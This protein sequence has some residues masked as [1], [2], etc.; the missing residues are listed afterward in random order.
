MADQYTPPKQLP[1]PE[2]PDIPLSGFSDVLLAEECSIPA[3]SQDRDFYVESPLLATCDIPSGEIIGINSNCKRNLG[4][5]STSQGES[6]NSD[7]Y[8]NPSLVSTCDIPMDEIIGDCGDNT[9]TLGKATNKRIYESDDEVPET[10]LDDSI[11][12]LDHKNQKKKHSKL[13]GPVDD[14]SVALPSTVTGG[15]VEFWSAHSSDAES[16]VGFGNSPSWSEQV[17]SRESEC[18]PAISSEGLLQTRKNLISNRVFNDTNN[19]TSHSKGTGRVILI[20]PS[21]SHPLSKIMNSPK[22]FQ[23]ALNST[24]FGKANIRDIRPNFKRGIIVIELENHDDIDKFDLLNITQMGEWSIK[25]AQPKSDIYS[26][27]IIAPIETDEE[28]S[29]SDLRV[30]GNVP[31]I[32]A[33]RLMRTVEDGKKVPSKCIKITFE[34]KDLPSTVKIDYFSFKVRRFVPSPLQCF[35]CQRLGHTSGGCKS[36]RPRCL[37]CKGP[38]SIKDK[39]CNTQTPKCANCDG[40]HKA[41][42]YLCNYLQ[43]GYNQDREKT[44]NRTPVVPNG[45]EGRHKN[46]S[47]QMVVNSSRKEMQVQAEVHHSMN[48]QVE[49]PRFSSY[50]DRVSSRSSP[51]SE[52]HVN[53]KTCRSCRDMGNVLKKDAC[54]QT[55]PE[56][57][58]K[59]KVVD[60]FDYSKLYKCLVELF[61]SNILR[62]SIPVRETLVKAALRHSFGKTILP[63]SQEVTAAQSDDNCDMEEEEEQEEDVLSDTC[64]ATIGSGT[65]IPDTPST[66]DVQA[67]TQINNCPQRSKGKKPNKVVGRKGQSIKES[68]K[69]ALQEHQI[70]SIKKKNK[71]KRINK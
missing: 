14:S 38:H 64:R 11:S 31:I 25:C 47:S 7:F 13:S 19:L 1:S 17:N 36:P 53:R 60:N 12:T 16:F 35:R 29:I 59:D 22:K 4:N 3:N 57:E 45:T 24:K 71:V 18:D 23:N 65:S 37:F 49:P 50:A 39:M 8:L 26:V 61:C 46:I 51:T 44:Q 5:S 69:L 42:S 52:L 56:Q 54:I 41:N 6:L 30:E 43:E 66:Q 32:K 27:G 10:D 33:E 20:T 63:S 40:P 62:E 2:P 9:K 70:P 67:V 68:Y 48:S 28:I 15:D 21:Q 34:S 55:D 58:P